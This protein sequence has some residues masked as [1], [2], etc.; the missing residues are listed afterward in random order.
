MTKPIIYLDPLFTLE[1]AVNVFLTNKIS[2]APV[3]DRKILVGEISRT[4]ILN[5]VGKQI[6]L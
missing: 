3:I 5:L 4:D 1:K 6:N 2:G